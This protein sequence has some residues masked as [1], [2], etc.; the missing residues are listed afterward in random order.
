MFLVGEEHFVAGLEV[1]AL[2]DGVHALGRVA[3][4]REFVFLASDE[5]SQLLAP[6][7]EGFPA[8]SRQAIA[9]EAFERCRLRKVSERRR[10]RGLGGHAQAANIQ[11]RAALGQQKLLAAEP[12]P[13][14]FGVA[15]EELVIGQGGNFEGGF[16][17]SGRQAE[18]ARGGQQ[19]FTTSHN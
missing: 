13:V 10:K 9:G 19:G 1:E 4:E 15:R 14:A 16:G 6:V 11:E 5:V 3:G 8:P 7:V 12:E 17:R 2:A 18:Q